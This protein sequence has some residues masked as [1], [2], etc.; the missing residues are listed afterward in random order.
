MSLGIESAVRAAEAEL[1]GEEASSH[2]V[3][4]E[5]TKLNDYNSPALARAYITSSGITVGN[6]CW[7]EDAGTTKASSTVKGAMEKNKVEAL[8]AAST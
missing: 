7:G 6:E 4:V 5:E 1:A 2:A 8:L 3:S